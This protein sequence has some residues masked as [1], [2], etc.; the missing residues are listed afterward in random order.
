MKVGITAD[1]HIGNPV[2]F[3]KRV[4]PGVTD[5]ALSIF[6]TLSQMAEQSKE[7]GAFVIAGDIFDSPRR[8]NTE[9]RNLTQQVFD[10][11]KC[12][13]FM[14]AGNHDR[15][16][17]S[18]LHCITTSFHAPKLRRW[19]LGVT[20]ENNHVYLTKDVSITGVPY[21]VEKDIL[22]ERIRACSRSVGLVGHR[23]L[24]LHG[25]YKGAKAASGYTFRD[26][27]I[28]IEFLNT[29]NFDLIV[30]G[31]VHRPEISTLYNGSLLLVPGPPLQH[32]FG[33]EDIEC[34]WWTYDTESRKLSHHKSESPKFRV[35]Q[36]DQLS[37]EYNEHDYFRVMT[38]N[39]K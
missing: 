15:N 32:N 2:Q 11:F 6:N 37:S 36:E 34:G 3:S 17:D 12:P 5:R 14:V 31:H 7:Y 23:I 4:R 35:I 19:V 10:K 28:D 20:K 8:I 9:L 25:W 24:L 16:Y 13:L 22:E 30:A 1:I 38:K 33:E 18:S 29:T 26:S 21:V 27:L 39:Q